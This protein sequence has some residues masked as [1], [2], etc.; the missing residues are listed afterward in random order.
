M[1][2]SIYKNAIVYRME[3]KMGSVPDSIYINNSNSK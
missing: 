1:K 3:Y 2:V